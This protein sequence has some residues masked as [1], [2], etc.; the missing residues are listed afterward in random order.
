[1]SLYF[2]FVDIA[3]GQIKHGVE[4]PEAGDSK[5]KMRRSSEGERYRRCKGSRILKAFGTPR[6]CASRKSSNVAVV[7]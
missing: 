3:F 6:I 2:D 5:A 1:M 7:C 4:D